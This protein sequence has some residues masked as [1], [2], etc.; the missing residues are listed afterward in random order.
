MPVRS[1]D[2]LIGL[3]K[4]S[5]LVTNKQLKAA[6]KG[7]GV[8]APQ[9]ILTRLVKAGLITEY[10]GRELYAGRN[11]GFFIGKYKV[12]R[13]LAAGGMG[14]VL[15]CEHV[16]MKHQVALKLLPQELGMQE[17]A[18]AR[19]Y[20]EARA[21][22]AVRHPNIVKAFDVGREGPWHCLVMEFVDG[23]NLHQVVLKHGP[24]GEVRA[25]HYIC[26]AAAGLEEIRK[27]GLVH[28]DLKPSNLLLEP[29]GTIKILDLGLA[30]FTDQRADDLTQQLEYEHVLGTADFISPEQALR[31]SDVDIRADIYALGMTFY[32]LLA[33]R[34]PF[35]GG[36]L[37]SKLMA[38]QTRMP[39]ALRQVR[40]DVDPRLEAIIVKMIQK[41]PVERFQTPQEVIQAM[42]PWTREALPPPEAQWFAKSG[43]FQLP[44]LSPST[45]EDAPRVNR[46]ADSEKTEPQRPVQMDTPRGPEPPTT[47]ITEISLVNPADDELSVLGPISDRL[48][49]AEKKHRMALN[50][51]QRRQVLI[52]MVIAAPFLGLLALVL[53]YVVSRPK[54]DVGTPRGR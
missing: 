16:H 52:A 13:P 51:R 15:H 46:P 7:T 2:E 11:Q 25:S 9:E 37:A 50:A 21:I 44:A 19:F 3:I 38:H 36:S 18:V 10:H 20:R 23:V 24:I 45:K 35:E 27:S 53:W 22:A 32:F 31:A 33:G 54:P 39:K 41:E 29:S 5:G 42:T 49:K 34:L 47:R 17:R 30:R 14:L 8:R 40:P 1:G 6:L 28:R 12:L 26:Q 48:A 4:K 43:S